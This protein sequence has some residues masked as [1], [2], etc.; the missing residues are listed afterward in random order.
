MAKVEVRVRVSRVV[1]DDEM[2]VERG[3]RLR[4]DFLEN[5]QLLLMSMPLVTQADDAAFEQ[6]EGSEQGGGAMST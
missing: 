6:F 1:V 4:V 5:G 2:Q 3:W